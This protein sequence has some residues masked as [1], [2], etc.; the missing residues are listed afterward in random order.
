[1]RKRIGA[2]L[3]GLALFV[4]GLSW[5]VLAAD[6]GN[7]P[8]GQAD[9]AETTEQTW[10]NPIYQDVEDPGSLKEALE[11]EEEVS[12]SEGRAGAGGT[13]T[14]LSMDRAADSLR[15]QLVAR[16]SPATVY[17]NAGSMDIH[18]VASTLYQ[19]AVS[20]GKGTAGNEGDYIV[21][22]LGGFYSSTARA[23]YYDPGRY[24]VTYTVSYYT[25]QQQ[26]RQMTTKVKSVLSALGVSKMST[27]GKIKT[28][29]DYIC[30]N[31]RYDYDTLYDSSKGKYTAY[32]A[33]M[34][35][36]AVC[37]GYASLFYR[38]A[39]DAGLQVRVIPGSSRGVPHAWNIVKLGSCYYNLDSTWDAGVRTPQYFLKSNRDF[40]D[41]TRDQECLTAAFQK[42]YPMTLKS[43][44][45]SATA[46]IY[47]ISK[48]SVSGIR[49]KTY[50]GKKQTQN[51]TLK[52]GN[53]TLKKDRDYT[54]SY[55]NNVN[56]GT[57]TIIFKGKGRY[58]GTLTK[59][60]KI[61]V[62]KGAV[63]KVGGYRYKIVNAST[64]GSGTVRQVGAS[65][66]IKQVKIGG[67]RFRVLK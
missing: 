41:H 32:N 2:L 31:V 21:Y 22:H 52:S 56:I 17:V 19:N 67:A 24:I 65:R 59:T 55:K 58:S 42:A 27:Y 25:T 28:I 13:V 7:G 49:A 38:M 61:V 43:Y 46:S 30:K 45:K 9:P 26:E 6:A 51:A 44:K 8:N 12:A 53:A 57:A 37:Q 35:K 50:T 62:K 47:A 64:N 20:V 36:K 39:T 66:N 14:Y 16:K 54:V 34:K 33:L 1:M 15:S 3:L 11:T 63:Y 40:P 29:H 10:I 4:N 48:V 60:F 5:E 23:S 18:S